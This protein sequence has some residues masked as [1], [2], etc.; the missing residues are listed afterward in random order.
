MPD[1]E[2]PTR[3][4]RSTMDRAIQKKG[5]SPNRWILIGGGA[6]LAVLAAWQ[7]LSR[8]GHTRLEV[9][10]DR[11]TTGVVQEGEFLEYYPFD[12]TV[13]PATSVYLDIEGG[14]RVEKIFVDG[15][16][17]VDKGDLIL[18][19]EN[20]SLRNTAISTETSLL[21]NLDIQRE[22]VFN[23]KQGTL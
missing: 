23:R 11:I 7:I 17:H 18:R 12:G 10:A 15:G 4:A 8:S 3:R 21:Y 16:Q 20:T 2:V 14:G 5:W 1:T 22:T 19:F 13:Q 6:L 9:D